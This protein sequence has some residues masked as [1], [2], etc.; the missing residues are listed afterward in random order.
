M[1]NHK[2]SFFIKEG[3]K[4]VDF[5]MHSVFLQHSVNT[6]VIPLRSDDI[7]ELLDEKLLKLDYSLKQRHGELVDYL[8]KVEGRIS[9]VENEILRRSLDSLGNSDSANLKSMSFIGSRD[10]TGVMDN[11]F[12]ELVKR[13]NNL[14]NVSLAQEEL[15]ALLGGFGELS[16]DIK[17]NFDNSNTV[18]N[19][20]DVAE[21]FGGEPK[22]LDSDNNLSLDA[23]SGEQDIVANLGEPDKVLAESI[24][25][26]NST[27]VALKDNG[28]HKD[29]SILNE[30]F[31]DLKSDISSYEQQSLNTDLNEAKFLSQDLQDAN[32]VKFQEKNETLND[33]TDITD[34]KIDDVDV[35]DGIN[36]E[37]KSD[38]SDLLATEKQE[39]SNFASGNLK[40]LDNFEDVLKA[41]LNCMDLQGCIK[42][43]EEK[44]LYDDT[45]DLE[46]KVEHGVKL[47][48][49]SLKEQGGGLEESHDVSNF[50]F[51][52]V[53]AII[54]KF[55]DNDYLSQIQLNKEECASLIKF[56]NELENE[57]S[58][59]LKSSNF[60]IKKEYEILQKIKHLLIRE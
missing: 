14:P 46:D 25:D 52:D 3:P 47:D 13:E 45:I 35:S 51:D 56:I 9:R 43:F 28:N 59:N 42:D 41:D 55:D 49:S 18:G 4:E 24:D 57:L 5:D 19:D 23:N 11:E 54:N 20:S 10:E 29:N 48:E 33:L 34:H 32:D 53:E 17:K 12:G 40:K 2:N 8:K 44:N 6:Q 15:D 26:E 50:S 7:K 37:E 38:N 21:V 30:P 16:G 60:K 22:S 31:S 39:I 58:L 1:V 27:G 36:L